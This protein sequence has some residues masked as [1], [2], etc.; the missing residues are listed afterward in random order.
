MLKIKPYLKRGDKY[1]TPAK[2]LVD[3][4]LEQLKFSPTLYAAFEICEREVRSVIKE[5][6]VVAIQGSRIVIR[7]PSVVHRQELLYSKT[8][9]LDRIRQALGRRFITDI[10]FEL[11]H[12]MA[13]SDGR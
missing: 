4:L 10:Q 2:L 3:S 7:V 12:D 11:K 6:E 8:R 1:N 9:I 13:T 5:C